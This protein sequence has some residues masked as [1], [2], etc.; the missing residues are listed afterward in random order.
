MSYITEKKSATMLDQIHKNNLNV[1]EES[2]IFS[3]D[4]SAGVTVAKKFTFPYPIRILAMSLSP[5][6]AL[7]GAADLVVTLTD[8]TTAITVTL[9]DAATTP[10]QDKESTLYSANSTLTLSSAACAGATSENITWQMHYVI[11]QTKLR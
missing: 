3:G 1:E 7:S 8:G 10:Q 5:Q 9:D 2:H 11:E 6:A 4:I